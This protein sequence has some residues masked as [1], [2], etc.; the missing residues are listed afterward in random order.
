MGPWLRI[1]TD[2]CLEEAPIKDKAYRRYALGVEKA[3]ALFETTLEEWADYISFL[4]RVLKVGVPLYLLMHRWH[5][6]LTKC[7]ETGP[8]SSSIFF[9]KHP[10]QGCRR[11]AIITMPQPVATVWSPPKN[12]RSIQLCIRNDRPRRSLTR[13]TF[14]PP[15]PRANSIFCLSLCPISLLRAAGEVLR[16]P[17]R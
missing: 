2:N 14:I 1:S 7:N 6:M 4:N 9:Y 16:W 13:P 5:C 15:W 17:R 10:R 12:P 8:S 11:E 3:L